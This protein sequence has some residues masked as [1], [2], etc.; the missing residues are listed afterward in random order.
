MLGKIIP[1]AT[2]LLALVALLWLI[3]MS[4]FAQ[5]QATT[6]NI[7]GRVLDPNEA[8]VPNAEVTA[9]NQATGLEKSANT[10]SEGNYSIILLP[11]GTYTVRVA[12]ATGFA[13]AQYQNVQVTVGSR[14]PLDIKLALAG[15]N[16]AAINVT[17][18]LP[19]V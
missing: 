14:T 4:A 18:E 1:H 7:E 16:V 11:P 12:Q 2:R 15:V 9:T 19:T 6:G 5:S 3:S 10:D 17:A 13:P 8:A